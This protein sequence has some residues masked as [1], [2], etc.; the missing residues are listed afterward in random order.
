MDRGKTEGI[1]NYSYFLYANLY[2]YSSKDLRMLMLKRY[3]FD[4][5]WGAKINNPIK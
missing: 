5:K 4:K 2:E 1:I 3:T